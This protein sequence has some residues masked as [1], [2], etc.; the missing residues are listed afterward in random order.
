MR[1]AA[2]QLNSTEDTSRN[3]ATADRLVRQA[4]ARGAELVVLPEKWSVLGTAEQMLAGAQ[5]LDG[6]CLTW[7]RSTA[8]ELAI[9]LVA[10]SIVER[11]EGRAKT[12]NTSVHVG[13]NGEIRAVYR[14]LHM[15]DVE[16]DDVA[17][18]ESDHESPA[19]RWSFRRCRATS[20]WG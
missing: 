19:M 11:V 10:G 5:S 12:S 7:A 1:A 4:A 18:N 14:K 15:F 8:G 3:L 13:S 20:D 6:E 16:V 9:D 2:V 17:Y